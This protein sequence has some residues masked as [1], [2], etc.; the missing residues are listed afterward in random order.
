MR[1]YGAKPA[2]I[3]V[4]SD[5]RADHGMLF[6][7]VPEQCTIYLSQPEKKARH[8]RVATQIAKIFAR[9]KHSVVLGVDERSVVDRIRLTVISQPVQHRAATS[10]IEQSY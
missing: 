9:H 4:R 8:I 5:E 6:G 2:L 3:F 1:D 7:D 10:G